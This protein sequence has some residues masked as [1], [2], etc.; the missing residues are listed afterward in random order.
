MPYHS[1]RS[2]FV[3]DLDLALL[4]VARAQHDLLVMLYLSP[5][6]PLS[7]I[8]SL[9]SDGSQSSWDTLDIFLGINTELEHNMEE[10]VALRDEVEMAQVLFRPAEPMMRVSSFYTTSISELDVDS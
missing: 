4:D 1:R 10:I 8:S 7:P 6:S 3:H 9:H 5:I 2:D